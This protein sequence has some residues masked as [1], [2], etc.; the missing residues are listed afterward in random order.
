MTPQALAQIHASAFEARSRWSTEDFEELISDP[1]VTLVA[2]EGGFILCRQILDEAE[3]LTLA[4][5]PELHR[6]GLAT[7]L[8]NMAVDLA[9][10]SGAT[11]M[12][13]EVADDNQSAIS[14]YR[15]TGF[16]NSGKRAAYY[17]RPD[18]ARVDA[19]LMTLNLLPSQG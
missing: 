3:I 8:V 11:K 14:L 10:Q 1:S 15:K 4:V 2:L 5:K 12:F 19:I 7:N 18:G 16:L 6:Q 17:R 13:L 9:R